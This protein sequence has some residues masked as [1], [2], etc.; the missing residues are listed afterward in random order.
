[1]QEWQK[2]AMS[3]ALKRLSKEDRDNW[4]IWRRKVFERLFVH[5]AAARLRSGRSLSVIFGERPKFHPVK[6]LGNDINDF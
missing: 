1:M 6:I 5:P 4:V 2:L 3:L